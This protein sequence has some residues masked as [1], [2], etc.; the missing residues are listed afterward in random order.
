MATGSP[1]AQ[2]AAKINPYYQDALGRANYAQSL[3]RLIEQLSKGVIAIDGE[4]GCGKS[5]F[6]ERL[7]I[8]LDQQGK[9]RTAWIDVFEADWDDDPTMSLIASIASQLS[10]AEAKSLIEKVTPY[11]SKVL[12]IATKAALKAAGNYLGVDKD[13]TE[14]VADAGKSSS[15]VYVKKHLEDAASTKK[16]LDDIKA[17]LNASIEGQPKKLVVFIDEL[18]RCSPAYAIRFLERLKHLF[19]LDGVIYILLW[20]RKQVQSSVELFYGAG[21]NGQMYLD[22]F[23]DYPLHLPLSQNPAGEPPLAPLIHSIVGELKGTPQAILSDNVHWIA[24]VASILQLTAREVQRVSAWYVLSVN[25]QFAVIETWLLGLKVKY[26]DIFAG[27]RTGN[28]EAHQKAHE[29]LRSTVIDPM[30]D[31]EHIKEL[32]ELH[33]RFESQNFENVDPHFARNYTG[34]GTD[35]RTCFSAAIRRLEQQFQ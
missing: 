21:S 33:S 16:N 8:D 7:R 5:W 22:K 11:L 1:Q 15:E 14:A 6:G 32:Q 4:W 19:D 24:A 10:E 34:M 20:N 26:P 2:V 35:I 31:G 9:T 23:V 28:R 25:R 29:L 17:L 30:A 13:I 12:P 3:I 18:D 27:I